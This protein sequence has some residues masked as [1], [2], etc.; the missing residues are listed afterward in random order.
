MGGR[1]RAGAEGNTRRRHLELGLS[2]RLE[3]N[4]TANTQCSHQT[5]CKA[6][7]G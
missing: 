4:R 2:V 3:K 6:L 5:S 1:G 7:E